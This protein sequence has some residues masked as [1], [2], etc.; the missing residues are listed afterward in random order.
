[1]SL[2]EKYQVPSI[3]KEIAQN[4]AD[5]R[6]RWMLKQIKPLAPHWLFK[7][8]VDSKSEDPELARKIRDFLGI[9]VFLDHCRGT[10]YIRIT[11]HG[12]FIAET[13]FDPF[14]WLKKKPSKKITITDTGI[15]Y[16]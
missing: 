9:R 10:E 16:E 6:D 15:N 11:Q 3:A 2:S 5:A 7:I 14:G 13:A 12:R 1:M 4:L 8:L